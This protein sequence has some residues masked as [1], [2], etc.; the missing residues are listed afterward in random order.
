MSQPIDIPQNE[1]RRRHAV[2][3]YAA[4]GDSNARTKYWV[5]TWN[6]YVE[7]EAQAKLAGMVE[8]GEASYIVCGKEIGESGTR[9]LQGYIEFPSR[10]R[11]TQVRNALDGCH[12][13]PRRGS[14]IQAKEYACKDGDFMEY[15]TM[16]KMSKGT[17]SDLQDLVMMFNTVHF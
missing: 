4:R 2:A 9:H 11:F 3:A 15:G 6:N 12:I 8:N 16:S 7:E 10:R 1:L 13:E 17:R 5:F 14:A